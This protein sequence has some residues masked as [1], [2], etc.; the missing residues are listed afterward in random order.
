[1]RNHIYVLLF[2]IILSVMGCASTED[3]KALR[4]ELNQK[5]EEKMDAKL[6]VVE[7]ELATL[8]KNLTALEGMRKEQANATAD[9]TDLRENLQQMR[10]QVEALKKRIQ[11]KTI[12]DLIT[13]S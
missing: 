7:A 13:F 3:L 6:A 1:M 11:K 8:K 10:G 2:L 12:N 9:I 4:S 5:M